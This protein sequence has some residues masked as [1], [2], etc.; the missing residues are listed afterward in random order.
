MR[1]EQVRIDFLNHVLIQGLYVEDK[2]GDTLLYAGE[3]RVRI[4]DWFIFRNEHPVVRYLG[5][6]DAYGHLYRTRSSDEWNY[7]FVID[8]FDTGVKDTTRKQNEFELD[9]EKIDLRNVRFHM[10]DAWVGSDFDIDVGN[11]QLDAEEINMREKLIDINSILIEGA[12]VAIRDYTGGRPPTAP[13]PFVLDTTAFNPGLWSVRIDDLTLNGSR[14][15]LNSAPE[16]E[17]YVNEFDPSHMDVTNIEIDAKNI[18]INGDTLH[19]KLEHLSANERS[20]IMIKRMSADV[21]VSPNASIADNLYLETNNSKLQHYY[22]M[23]YERFPDFTDYVDKVIMVA[24]ISNSRIDSRDVAYFAPAL[25]KYPTIVSASGHVAGTVD[26]LTSKRLYVTDGSTFLKGDIS[27]IGLPDIYSTFIRIDNGD[28]FTNNQS[29]FKYAP[30]LRRHPEIAF[31]ELN[32]LSYKGDFAGYIENFVANGQ[33]K[34]NLGSITSTIKLDMPGFDAVSSA[35]KGNISTSGFDL[36][37]LFRQPLL[38]NIAFKA[39]ITGKGFDPKSGSMQVNAFINRL[40]FNGYSYQN[41]NAEGT[42]AKR[43]FTGNLIVDDPNLALAFNGNIDFNDDLLNITAKANLLTSDLRAINLTKDSLVASADFDV[44]FIGTHIDNFLGDAK[45]YNIDIRRG[46]HR[47]DI[48]SVFVHSDIEEDERL[49]TIESNDVAARLTGDFQL[50]NLQ[51]SLQF[52]LSGYLP[53]YI[54]APVTYAPDQDISFQITTRKI[55]SLLSVLV[56]TVQGFD[57]STVTGTLHTGRQ[58]L[59]LNAWIPFAS[60]SNVS[61]Y[62]ASIK[63]SGSHKNLVLDSDIEKVSV[64]ND[65]LSASVAVDASLGSDSLQF[66]IATVSPDNVGTSNINGSAYASG[67]SLYLRVLPSEFFIHNYKWQIPAGNNF[68]FSKEYLQIRSFS[69]RSQEQLIKVFTEDEGGSQSVVVQVK[70][71]SIPMVG[72]L[73]GI[74]E[75]NPEGKVNGSIRVDHIFNGLEV[76]GNLRTTGVRLGGD[77]IGTINVAGSYNAKKRIINLDPESGVF[78]GA[79]SIRAAGSMSFDSTSNQQLNGYVEFNEAR[80]AWIAPLVSDFLGEMSGRLNGTIN[81]GGSATKP[82]IDGKVAINTAA[83]RIN[84]IGTYYKIPFAELTVSNNAIDF[85]TVSIFDVQNN[86]ATLTGGIAHD[87]F[88]NMRLNRVNLT[89]PHFEVLNLKEHEN[90]SFYGNLTA[91]VKSL[92]VSGPFD[93]LTMTINAT[94]SARSHIF[95]PVKTSADI[96]TYSYVSFKSYEDEEV[97]A[98]RRKKNKFSLTINGEMNPL[99][100]MTLVLD[101]STGDMIN[102]K[103]FG[104]IQLVVPSD[105]EIKMYGNYHIEEGDYT[106]TLR[107][108]YFRRNFVINSGSTIAF[109]GVLANTNLDIDAVY[110]RTARLIDLL[111]ESEKEYI[112]NTS[113]EREAKTAQNV[114]VLLHMNGSLNEPKLSFGID[115]EEKREGA[116]AYQKLKQINLDDRALFDQVAALLL[117]GTFIPQEGWG[118]STANTATAGAI[119]NISDIFSSTA[120]TQLTNIVNKLLG[121]PDLSIELKYKNYN[122]SDPLASS[123]INRNEVSFGVR[124]NLLDDRLLVELGSAYDWGRP[125]SSNSST[126]N[127]NLAGDFR[128]QYLL[129]EDGQVRLNAFRTSN[130]DVLVDRN[131]WRGGFGIS[132]RR[133]FN[134]LYE[135]FHKAKPPVIPSTPAPAPKDTVSQSSTT[136]LR[137]PDSTAPIAGPLHPSQSGP[138]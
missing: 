13:K 78:L 132:Y 61:F 54:P 37:R 122:L 135:F 90:A 47:L 102:A 70:D 115:L 32:Y 55:D 84:I 4:T 82:D 56:P 19:G 75:Y 120:S 2:A 65:V 3:A 114:N 71:L 108:L 105:D 95:I 42:L 129:T 24:D 127:L 77:V 112:R 88:R 8:A 36:G 31:E 121:D 138:E 125:T 113:E 62:N 104:N 110:T 38:G 133:S 58:E 40:D 107:Q 46:T 91:N 23:H 14:F 94:P 49:L 123:G 34:T 60:F 101:P 7:Q 118:G 87:R 52:Y 22:A 97:I 25:R 9:L 131:I 103:G 117:V 137:L 67:D 100:Q 73:A 48:D 93:D 136:W 119:N 68:V 26:S 64:G 126:S 43:R 59:S 16:R 18:V 41:L 66:Q 80:L 28:I 35:Y 57:S 12:T 134:N 83:T 99:A 17:A 89:A 30:E 76:A 1:V 53:N 79:S 51:H 5:L 11:L 111:N 124:K 44:N 15:S 69:L 106:F 98:S 96:N 29:I 10:D 39:D 85:G 116:I 63:G 20:G 109:N 86:S 130:Y 81:V 72:K 45:L 74:A 128:V 92:T 33:L 6:H 50:S 27:M 21:T